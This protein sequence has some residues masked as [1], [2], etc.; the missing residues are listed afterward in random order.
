[1]GW[2]T[3]ESEFNFRQDHD[4]FLFTT[5]S[6]PVLGLIQHPIQ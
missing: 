5:A 6:R 4:I 1:M 2:A 3:E